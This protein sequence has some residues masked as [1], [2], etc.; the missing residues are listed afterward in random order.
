MNAVLLLPRLFWPLGDS[1]PF[2]SDDARTLE[3]RLKIKTRDYMEA[4]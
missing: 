1:S 3:L 4:S 2:R